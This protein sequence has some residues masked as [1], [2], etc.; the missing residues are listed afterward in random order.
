MK[1]A[2]L[3]Y[4]DIIQILFLHGLELRD[5]RRDAGQVVL[6]GFF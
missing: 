5:A 6:H 3:A 2:K 4:L 1:Q